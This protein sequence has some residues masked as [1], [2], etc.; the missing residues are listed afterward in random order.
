MKSY[1]DVSNAPVVR[2]LDLGKCIYKW[3]ME[4]IRVVLEAEAIWC[5]RIG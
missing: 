4:A 2:V 5:R 1:K 3:E